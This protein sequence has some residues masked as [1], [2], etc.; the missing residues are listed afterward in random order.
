[1]R[2][3]T[4]MRERTGFLRL[5]WLFGACVA[6]VLATPGCDLLGGDDDLEGV[7]ESTDDRDVVFIRVTDDKI[8]SYDF[9]GDA[10]DEGEDCY[11]IE[12]LE[13]ISHDGDDYTVRAPIFE[14]QQLV[15]KMVVD[16]D[17]LTVTVLGE[18]ETFDR[19]D[20]AVSSF[21]PE[22]EEG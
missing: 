18:T 13:I 17:R 19:S 9:Q 7:W 15:I 20:R 16:G 22:C 21:T 12:D 3:Y 5:G 6:I 11:E 14:N 2:P 8:T 10:E 1:M 4:N